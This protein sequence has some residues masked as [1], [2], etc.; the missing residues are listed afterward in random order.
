[1]HF[2]FF[3]FLVF[4]FIDLE[5]KTNFVKTLMFFKTLS[6]ECYLFAHLSV[7]QFVCLPI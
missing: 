6:A 5:H 7:L 1:M 2:I 3:V 4:Y